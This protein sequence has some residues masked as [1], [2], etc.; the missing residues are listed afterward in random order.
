[1][2]AYEH[3]LL[4]TVPV[5]VVPVAGKSGIACLEL[6]QLFLRSRS[7]PLPGLLEL[8]LTAGLL[9]HVGHVGV[10]SEVAYTFGADNPCRP[11]PGD[12]IVELIDV[13]RRTPVI[14]KGAY[15]VLL[16]L[17]L[18]VGM[19]MMMAFMVMMMMPVAAGLGLLLFGGNGLDALYPAGG[20]RHGIEGKHVRVQQH[21][22]VHTG[23]VALYYLYRRLYR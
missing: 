17:T 14:D 16:G 6:L 12:E 13:K 21:V 10:L 19:I 4:H 1:M 8:F 7:I 9:E 3:N 5:P 15:A 11:V 2:L 22:D 18:P 23:I 20:C